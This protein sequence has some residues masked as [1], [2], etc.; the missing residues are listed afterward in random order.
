MRE[1]L[2]DQAAEPK[3]SIWKNESG[4]YSSGE[5]PDSDGDESIGSDDF[6]DASQ[7]LGKSR[8]S[9]FKREPSSSMNQSL[10]GYTAFMLFIH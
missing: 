4:G 2:E 6:V 1:K 5:F 8:Q 10:Y 7:G 3:A 9:K